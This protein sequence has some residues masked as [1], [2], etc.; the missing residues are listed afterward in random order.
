M[1]KKMI[2][3]MR[4]IWTLMEKVVQMIIQHIAQLE[5][6]K[7][8]FWNTCDLKL[9]GVD[10]WA[11]LIDV[12]AGI[13]HLKTSCPWSNVSRPYLSHT[14]HFISWLF[15]VLSSAVCF[16]LPSRIGRLFIHS[17]KHTYLLLSRT[18]WWKMIIIRIHPYLNMRNC[19]KNFIESQ[20]I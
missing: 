12:V 17:I 2:L 11:L 20:D 14:K 10:S 7:S 18:L 13:I 16:R 6:G 3:R 4:M 5:I 9:L 8:I 15:S 19:K 1:I